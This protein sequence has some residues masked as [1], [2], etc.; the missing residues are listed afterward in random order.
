MLLLVSS[1]CDL[2][3]ALGW[4]AAE[5]EVVG[6]RVSTSKSEAMVLC[7]KTVGCSLWDRSKSL[8]RGK[9]FKYLWVLFMS[10]NKMDREVDRR[11]SAVLAVMQA[12]YWI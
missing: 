3:Q 12:L 6:M 2:Q 7:W 5:C 1:D 10:E 8:L 11:I 4:F 9:E